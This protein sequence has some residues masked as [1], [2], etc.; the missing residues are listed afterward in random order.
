MKKKLFAPILGIAALAVVSVGAT[1]ALFS[2][3]KEANVSIQAGTVKVGMTT[4][5]SSAYSRYE[6]ISPY[7]AK[8][9]A[10]GTAYVA[11]YENSG[12]ASVGL[13]ASNNTVITL[14][15][16]TPMD[17]ITLL[18]SVINLSNV[19]I[20]YRLGFEI[21][22]E[23]IPALEIK[24]DGVDYS[25]SV[26]PVTKY[27]LWSDVIDPSTIDL[28]DDKE[29][30]IAFPNHDDTDKDFDDLYQGKSGIIKVIAEVVQGN[31]H[32]ED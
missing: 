16:M 19:K 18:V 3:K 26:F 21:S 24:Y 15:R 13:E 6:D 7:D 14:D 9:A 11:I 22:G 4:T 30:Y 28:A 10:E 32:V 27:T 23:L 5:V 1:Y 25:S 20:K 2:D 31:A 8:A 17:N 12:T 29:L